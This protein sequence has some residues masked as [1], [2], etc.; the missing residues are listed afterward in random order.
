MMWLKLAHREVP[1]HREPLVELAN[2]YYQTQAWAKCLDA[3]KQALAITIHP[4]DYS[5]S[6]EAWGALPFDLASIAAWNLKLYLDARSYATAAVGLDPT[7]Q[8]IQNNLKLIED[9]IANLNK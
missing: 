3:A 7:N 4:R 8:R 6:A 5:C 9:E 2:H 1:N